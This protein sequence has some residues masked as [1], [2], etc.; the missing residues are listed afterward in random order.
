LRERGR[1]NRTHILLILEIY[2][3]N[4]SRTDEHRTIGRT[5]SSSPLRNYSLAEM[6]SSSTDTRTLI[7]LIPLLFRNAGQGRMI[8]TGKYPLLNGTSFFIALTRANR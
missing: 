3:N 5:F 6:I 2:I 7:C 4:I 1:G 8:R